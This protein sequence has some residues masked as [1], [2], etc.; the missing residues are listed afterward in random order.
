[1]FYVFTP[2]NHVLMVPINFDRY[3]R[4]S[5]CCSRSIFSL[6]EPILARTK[7]KSSSRWAMSWPAWRA[8]KEAFAAPIGWLA[9]SSDSWIWRSSA[10]CRNSRSEV[11][12]ASGSEVLFSESPN[13]KL[14]AEVLLFLAAVRKALKFDI[15][16]V[17]YGHIDSCPC[18]NK[19]WFASVIRA[20]ESLT[21]SREDN[22]TF[23]WLTNS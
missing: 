21:S 2:E 11:Q 8:S 20:A 9:L 3:S 15:S 14:S 19:Y 17:V 23:S 22:A 5:S 6:C 18:T 13:V 1:M 7:P 10:G 12:G 4:Y 16:S